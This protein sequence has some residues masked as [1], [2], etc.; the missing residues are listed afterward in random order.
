MLPWRA[1]YLICKCA[2]L[3]S[4]ARRNGTPCSGPIQIYRDALWAGNRS[5]GRALLPSR[6]QMQTYL[7]LAE[8]DASATSAEN[9]F[10]GN[11]HLDMLVNSIENIRQC[12]KH[13]IERFRS[14][15]S[16]K[17]C[18]TIVIKHRQLC[19]I[20][21][22]FCYAVTHVQSTL[23]TRAAASLRGSIM[24]MIIIIIVFIII[25]SSSSSN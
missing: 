16:N 17:T 10:A 15:F 25:I 4:R 5:A 19:H 23:A 9:M 6:A 18:V 13:T 20:T 1:R 3:S 7:T 14:S 24:M 11:T 22:Y 8:L 21:P 12:S 2:R